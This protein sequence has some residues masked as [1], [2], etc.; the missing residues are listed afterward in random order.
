MANGKIRINLTDDEYNLIN[1]LTRQ[2]KTDCWFCLDKDNDGFDCVKDLE[3]GYKITLRCALRELNEAIVPELLNVT[4]SEIEL[5]GNLLG[6]LRLIYNPFVL[7]TGILLDYESEMQGKYPMLD[8]IEYVVDDGRYIAW[9]KL[10]YWSTDSNGG[11]FSFRT[12]EEFERLITTSIN[13]Y[14]EEE[15]SN[16]NYQ[17][18]QYGGK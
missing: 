7:G 13:K 12:I 10:P 2:T 5:Y 1:K 11:F 16:G 18:E 3:Q 17:A 15:I 9:L 8:G 4:K 6:K 14:T